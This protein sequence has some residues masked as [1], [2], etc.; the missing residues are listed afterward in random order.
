MGEKQKKQ[1]TVKK[2]VEY[3]NENSKSKKE[4]ER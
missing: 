3:K 2:I 4:K 1:D